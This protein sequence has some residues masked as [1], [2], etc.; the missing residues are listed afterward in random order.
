MAHNLS[1][2]QTNPSLSLESLQHLL[3]DQ[4]LSRATG[5]SSIAAVAGMLA[6]AEIDSVACDSHAADLRVPFVARC[7]AVVVAGEDGHQAG[8][9]CQSFH[10][11]DI[12]ASVFAVVAGGSIGTPAIGLTG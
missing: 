1:T 9:G 12:L 7:V 2:L 10:E 8:S 6:E 3:S 4:N 5:P 11:G